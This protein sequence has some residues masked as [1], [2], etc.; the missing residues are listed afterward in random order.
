MNQDRRTL[1]RLHRIESTDNAR[2]TIDTWR[3]LDELLGILEGMVF[4]SAIDASWTFH[5]VSDA[6]LG[7]TGYTPEEILENRVISY[8]EI[9]HPED[10]QW[11][12]DAILT[13]LRESRPYRIQYRIR[14]KD[15]TEKIVL[16]RGAGVLD[17]TGNLVLEGIVEDISEQHVARSALAAAEERYRSIFEHSSEGIFQSTPDGRYLNVNPALAHMYGYPSPAS[18]VAEVQDIGAQLYV[19]PRRRNAFQRI[20]DS[21]GRVQGFESQVR[22]R[23]GSLI[24]IRENARAVRATDGRLVYYE[25]TVED[26]T[27]A[28]SY[29]V[30]LEHQA[31]H[32]QLTGLPNRNL[33]NDRLQQ[34]IDYAERNS[35]Y[36]AVAF[37]DVDN[38]KY[39][40]DGLGHVAG[41]ALLLAIAERLKA[42]LRSGDT[43]ARYGGDEFVLILTNHYETTSIVRVLER[44]VEDVKRP[45]AVS[46]K[47]LLVTCSIGVSVYPEDGNDAQSLVKHADA[48]MYLA[49]RSG[50]N[51]FKFFTRRLNTMA[52]ERVNIERHLRRAIERD[53]LRVH[54]QPKM[55]RRRRPIGVEALVR[56]ESEDLGWMSPDKFIGVAEETGLIEPITQFV[57]RCACRQAVA[58]SRQGLGPLTMAV[59][60]SARCL[61]QPGLVAS[62]AAVLAETGLEPGRLEL[63]VTESM[64][65]GNAEP[66]IALLHQI[67]ALGVLLAVDDFGTGYS[68]LSYLQ[69]LPVDILKI[70]RA[71][72]S[73]IDQSTGE[74][75]IASL[76]VL[77][78]QSLR[79]RVVAE[80][81]ETEIQQRYL[82]SLGCD[83]Y[84][85]YLHARPADAEQITAFFAAAR[86]AS[87]PGDGSPFVPALHAA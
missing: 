41:D 10:R 13:A 25:G 72:V 47:E 57:L 49:K 84:Q 77:L 37:I 18:L 30:Q 27:T 23:D 63:E 75:P 86:A 44:V 76:I 16:D 48:A 38:F 52:T 71:F 2:P 28:K 69:R 21:S 64:V 81:V 60:L 6:C 8:E 56:W 19:D 53:E 7:L 70:D 58:W 29:Q 22:R 85:G 66:A 36:A 50:R 32:D 78:G 34:A 24:W 43:V 42:C 80:G 5:L 55:D 15:G 14:C 46:D 17:E 31:K 11:V 51:N 40:N 4:R 87:A 35:F 33:L 61:S 74:S 79:L 12:R 1:A 39:I 83:E 3:V 73:V 9:T 62:I 54:Y 20:M 26:I 65:I 68:S 82:E 67:K 45:I 59:N